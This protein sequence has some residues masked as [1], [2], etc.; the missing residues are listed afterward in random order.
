MLRVSDVGNA[1]P[2]RNNKGMKSEE[3]TKPQAKIIQ[4]RRCYDD[5]KKR[6]MKEGV[7]ILCCW[8]DAEQSRC[9]KMR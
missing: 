5:E 3:R 8:V 9:T 7:S 4:E 1:W 6:V 2:P